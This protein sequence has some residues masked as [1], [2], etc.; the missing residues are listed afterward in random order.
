MASSTS[1][2][3][4]IGEPFQLY[5]SS[6]SSQKPPDYEAIYSTHNHDS[7][8]YATV[9]AQADGIHVW[10]L[11][12]LHPVASYSVGKHVIFATPTYSLYVTEEGNR[13]VISY[14]ALGLAPDIAKENRGRTIWVI[15]QSLSGSSVAASEK[16]VVVVDRPPVRICGTGHD[17]APLL[18]VS[19]NGSLSLANA[20]VDIK[21][22]LDW[23]GQRKHLETF[24]FPRKSCSFIQDDTDSCSS[25]AITCCQTNMTLYVRLMLLGEEIVLV[26][27]CEIP[28]ASST[29]DTKTVILG[30]TC[31]PSGVLS[32]IDSCGIWVTYQLASLNSSLVLAPISENLRLRR[33]TILSSKKPSARNGFSVISLGTSLVL[34][35]ALVEG[36]QNLSLQIWDLSYGV[37]LAAQSMPVPSALS[38]AN[39]SLTVADEGQVLLTVSSSQLHEKKVD[40]KRSSIHIV[41][42]D[43]RL[44][45]SLATAL[46]KT[47][48]TAEWLIPKTSNSR[49]SEEDD[50]SAKIIS[51]IEAFLKKNN[52]QKAEQAFLKWVDSKSSKEAAL[53]HEFVKKIFNI[54]LPPEPPTNYPYTPR[55]TRCLL[56]N[57]VVSTI[58]LN[59]RLITTLRQRSD[60]ENVM[61]ALTTVADVSEDELMASAKFLIDRQRRSENVM[62]I[63]TSEGYVPPLWSY[64]FACV[65]YPFSAA[66]MR[67]AIR[68][69]L[70]DAQDLVMI[71]E[72]LENWIQG[73]TE[74]EVEVLLKSLATNT[75]MPPS[76]A[77]SPP[78]PK[79]FQQHLFHIATFT[80]R[81]VITFL[82]ALLDASFVA[83]LQYQP[84]HDPLRRIL[85]Y[86]GPEITFIDSLEPLRGVLEP[87]V[88]AQL[89]KERTG[90]SKES[91]A[92]WRK[93]KKQLEQQA[94][95]GVGLYKLEE[96]V[97]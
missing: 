8:G 77:D 75:K 5:L 29:S 38:L 41:P 35:A 80:R 92:E 44:K 48:L 94:G 70:P 28:I 74:H 59:G 96:L 95:L 14:T 46:G 57:A 62:D 40:P 2:N 90:A 67:L 52:A 50:N 1:M 20:Q 93:R 33:F 21:S 87:F 65:S 34:L 56:E 72:I 89:L 24:V 43:A 60:W 31:S 15:R 25:V 19:K 81:Q 58:M 42:V 82:Q 79:V 85:S 49:K 97:I 37:I 66:P 84:S 88:K 51:D 30:L 54:V 73:G 17:I 83:L 47:A 39:L 6:T 86:I 27:A 7:P 45:S 12:N 78:Y 36:T 11:Q 61:F 9:T 13:S 68:K 18:F 16:I 4:T 26:G 55:I 71:L 22:Q 3:S 64:L 32:F 91:P 23:P 76:R 53:G 63:D 69:Y 10:D